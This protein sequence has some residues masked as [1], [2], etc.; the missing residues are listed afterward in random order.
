[1][2]VIR[3]FTA[4]VGITCA[5]LASPALAEYPDKPVTLVVPY[6]P[7][8]AADLAARIIANEAPEYLGGNVLVVNQAGAAGVTGSGQS[9]EKVSR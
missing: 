5:G 1:M 6:G 9:H 2:K 4:V 3:N 8:G 7:G